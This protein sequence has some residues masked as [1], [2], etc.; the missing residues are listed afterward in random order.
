VDHAAVLAFRAEADGC[1]RADHA[2]ACPAEV[3]EVEPMPGGQD[4]RFVL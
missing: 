3:L 2:I 4:P 1:Q